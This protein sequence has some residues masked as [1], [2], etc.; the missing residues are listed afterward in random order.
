MPDT[1][2]AERANLTAAPLQASR[3][4][5][6]EQLPPLVLLPGHMSSA[7][8]WEHQ[9]RP[10]RG[11]RTVIVPDSHYGLESIEQM[12][13]A[14]AAGLP[15]R[16]DLVS[17][18]MGGY[19]A[20]ELYPLVRD[21]IRTLTLISTSARAENPAALIRRGEF[22][23]TVQAVGLRAAY[24][25]SLDQMIKEPQ[26]IEPQ[27]KDRIIA[28]AMRFGEAVLFSQIKA[29]IGRHDQRAML[30]QIDCPTLVVVGTED[31]IVPSEY[32]EELARA[33]P[34]AQVHVVCGTGHCAPWE[35]ADEINQVLEAFWH[36]KQA[37]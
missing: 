30:P 1:P 2:T 37:G 31:D 19:I 33:I 4:A 36:A 24:I 28:E 20:L 8:T 21:R 29:M 34:R 27:F 3:G 32:T 10:L 16:F 7:T 14:I 5:P 25:A 6:A 12:A 17:W 23:R 15:E 35:R 11:R 13:R 26:H 18:S 22:L 9:C